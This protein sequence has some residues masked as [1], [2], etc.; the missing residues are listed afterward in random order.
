MNNSESRLRT[1]DNQEVGERWKFGNEKICYE[2]SNSR[3]S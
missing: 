2:L 1:R 3:R